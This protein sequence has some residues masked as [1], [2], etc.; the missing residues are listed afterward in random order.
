MEH[1][2]GAPGRD[3]LRFDEEYMDADIKPRA[4]MDAERRRGRPSAH[5]WTSFPARPKKDVLPFLLEHAPLRNRER[6][7]I[8]MIRG[9]YLFLRAQ[10][11][12]RDHGREV[13]ELLAD[14]A[15]AR[16]VRTDRL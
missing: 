3:A 11:P 9:G 1:L 4:A 13:G 12:P 8:R 15:A 6:D 14:R 5:A 2:N 7:V 10:R 16:S